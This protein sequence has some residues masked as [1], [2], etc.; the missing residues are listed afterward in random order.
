MVTQVQVSQLHE[1]RRLKRGIREFAFYVVV[2]LFML[3]FMGVFLWM[4]MASLK[5][6]LQNTAIPP[7]LVFQPTL[8]NY[9]N[10]ISCP[11]CWFTGSGTS[12]PRLLFNSLVVS[13][14]STA[15]GLILGLPAAYSI[16]R[17]KQ[18]RLGIAVLIARM[19]PGITFLLPWFI[20]FSR[21]HLVGTYAVLILA[22]LVVT[23]PLITWITI[24][25]FEDVPSEI[26]DAAL[27]DGCSLLDVFIR[28]AVPLVRS[29]IACAA[30]LA[31]I[32][33]WNT[34]IFALVLSGPETRTVPVGVIS[35]ISDVGIDWGRM[36][37]VAVIVTLPVMFLAMAVQ[38]YIVTGLTMGGV[39][40]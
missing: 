22:H 39:K 36:T 27:I 33:V 13:L 10:V 2:I 30:I 17:F 20:V 8:T 32:F 37:A 6:E 15:L 3:P 38:R 34:F 11:T 35:Y 7:I 16:A 24:G 29:G 12:I 19:I 1:R 21:L 31:F 9:F 5:N 4:V 25:F 18:Q 40:G 26:E 14:G 23:L 28:V